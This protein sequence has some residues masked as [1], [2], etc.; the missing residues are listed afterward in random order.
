MKEYICPKNPDHVGATTEATKKGSPH[1]A[2]VACLECNEFIKWASREDILRI[3][4]EFHLGVDL[5]TTL[6]N[7]EKHAKRAIDA[8]RKAGLI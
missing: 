8:L 6:A 1:N 5:K 4:T 3:N 2:R 7:F